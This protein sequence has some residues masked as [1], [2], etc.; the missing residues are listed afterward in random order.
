MLVLWALVGYFT[1]CSL[2]LTLTLSLWGELTD[3]HSLW[4]VSTLRCG[5]RCIAKSYSERTLSIE[6]AGRQCFDICHRQRLNA[7]VAAAY[8]LRV[9]G[10]LALGH[11]IRSFLNA[12][13]P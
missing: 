12:G 2:T 4:P 5:V 13:F 6:T 1:P 11:I 9:N 7:T 8:V 10:P 3:M